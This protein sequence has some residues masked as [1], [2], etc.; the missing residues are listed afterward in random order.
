M[1]LDAL[2][3][4]GTAEKV[5]VN[6][7]DFDTNNPRFTPD[8]RPESNEDSAIVEKLASTADLAELTAIM[9]RFDPVRSV[10]GILAS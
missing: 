6:L 1:N 8:K 4:I 7:F 5:P 3:P 2:L 9:Q 10:T